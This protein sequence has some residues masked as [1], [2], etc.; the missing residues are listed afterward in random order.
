MARWLVL[1]GIFCLACAAQASYT[2]RLSFRN[3]T[4]GE[5]NAGSLLASPGDSIEIW[6]S[7]HALDNVSPYK[8]GT[9]Q[10]TLCLDGLTLVGAEDQANWSTSIYNAIGGGGPGG[11]IPSVIF[12]NGVLH[13]NAIDPTDPSQPIVCNNGLYVL[14]GMNGSKAKA[15][16]WDVMFWS[17]TV[18]PGS[19]GQVL[20][21]FFDGRSTPTGLST[22]IL[23]QKNR[24]VDATDN[25]VTVVPEPGGLAIAATFS[26]LFLR[27]RR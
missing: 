17:F 8:W 20:D 3:A 16:N 1:I 4:T 10:I 9:L 15:S 19:E 2:A 21:W 5:D 6:Y 25:W 18:Q 13:D 26:L 27:R 12:G 22:R 23:D 11:D 24:T 14:L 7:F